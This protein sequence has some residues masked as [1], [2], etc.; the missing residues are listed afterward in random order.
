M[1]FSPTAPALRPWIA[2]NIAKRA[3]TASRAN[4]AF[5]AEFEE[6]DRCT[7]SETVEAK[8]LWLL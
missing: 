6:L 8:R 2:A 4:Q 1:Q 3:S 5:Y 7:A